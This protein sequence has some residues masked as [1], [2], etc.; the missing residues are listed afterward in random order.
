M[1]LIDKIVTN[2]LRSNYTAKYTRAG[3]LQTCSV[4]Y[5]LLLLC[6]WSVLKDLLVVTHI[7]APLELI[8]I[9][10]I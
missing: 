8:A 9:F 3:V 6:E 1:L 5:Y 7:F 10:N 4:T 2:I